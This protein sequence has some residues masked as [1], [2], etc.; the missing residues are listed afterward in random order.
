MRLYPPCPQG[1]SIRENL[2]LMGT[3]LRFSI[4][5]QLGRAE[6]RCRIET[7]FSKLAEQLPGGATVCDQRWDGDRLAFSI[8]ALS[9]TVSGGVE[10]LETSVTIDVDLPGLLGQLA[11]VFMD[12]LQKAGQRLLTK[13]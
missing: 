7:G 11:D 13:H 9:Q 2:C 12:R 6:A 4:L 10:V 3:P 8:A 5:H 1:V